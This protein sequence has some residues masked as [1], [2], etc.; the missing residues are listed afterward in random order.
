[1]FFGSG[2]KQFM[3]RI[4]IVVCSY[5]E[6]QHVKGLLDSLCRQ[7]ATAGTF[8]L[9]FIDNRSTDNTREIVEPYKDRFDLKYIYESRLGL[10]ISRN[11]GFR[12]SDTN[13]VAFTD[14][15]GILD[16]R[17]VETALK[18]IELESPDLFGGPYFPYYIGPKPFWF[19]DDYNSSNPGNEMRLL[20]ED[21]YLNGINMIWKREIL[22]LLGG[23]NNS[24]GL[25]GRKGSARGAE[26][27]IM[28]VAKKR[29]PNL[30]ILYCPEL[31][32]LHLTRPE[33]F[34]MFYWIKRNFA[35]GLRHHKI[36]SGSEPQNFVPAFRRFLYFLRQLMKS[37]N[38]GRAR[39][40]ALYPAWQNYAYE[41]VLP[42]I[43]ANGRGLQEV[44]RAL[45]KKLGSDVR[46]SQSLPNKDG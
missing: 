43:Y 44:I 30:K 29:F 14:A 2:L 45:T 28:H 41:K 35:L 24:V 6:A 23:F 27:N 22:E 31:I 26:T 36:W 20:K 12:A 5:N 10:N 3:A 11:N 19:K 39:D 13:Y 8:R 40:K 32:A 42:W 21:E 46:A 34:S 37:I 4:D 15:D 38:A 25:S 17:W 9:L 1:M 7:T 18:V 33:T 16:P